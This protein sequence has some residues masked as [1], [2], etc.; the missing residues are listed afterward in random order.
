MSVV[1][2]SSPVR[3]VVRAAEAGA[4]EAAPAAAKEVARKDVVRSVLE[5]NAKPALV[6]DP[7]ALGRKLWAIANAL[8]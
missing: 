8:F 1:P 2:V 5:A 6:A 3:P 7:R 4:R